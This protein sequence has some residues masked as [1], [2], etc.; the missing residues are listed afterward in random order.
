MRVSQKPCCIQ[1]ARLAARRCVES[2]DEAGI[3][4]LRRLQDVCPAEDFDISLQLGVVNDSHSSQGH[5]PD[6]NATEL[7]E[8]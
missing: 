2:L 5:F 1:R 4:E 7:Q 6:P 8:A 3:N